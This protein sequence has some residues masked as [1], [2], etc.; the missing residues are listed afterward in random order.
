[1][2]VE[3][4]QA[5]VDRRTRRR[6]TGDL[7]E[8]AVAQRLAA[9]GWTILDRNVRVGRIEVDILARDPEAVPVIVEVRSRSTPGFGAPEET[10]S[11]QKVERLYRAA[12]QLAQAGHSIDG[13][14]S[15][16]PG[17]RVDLVTVEQEMPTGGWRVTRHVRGLEPPP[18][19]GGRTGRADRSGS[20]G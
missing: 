10:V 20:R 9:A 4:R 12:W 13:P 3:G 18:W 19:G 15:P 7:A 8:A 2:D 14:G 6:V 17:W 1:M 11:R 16:W 5:P